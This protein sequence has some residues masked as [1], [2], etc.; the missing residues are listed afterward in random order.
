[1]TDSKYKIVNL[2]FKHWWKALILIV[3]SGLAFSGWKCGWLSFEKE[4]IKI[5]STVSEIVDEKPEGVQ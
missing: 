5:K 3:A 2:I 4:G 1:M